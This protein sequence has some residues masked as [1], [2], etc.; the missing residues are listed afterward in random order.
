MD[1][2]A[3]V[4]NPVAHSK[5]PQI[6]E[7]FARETGQD[8]SYERILAPLGGFAAAA[9]C[10]AAEGGKGINVTVPFKLD[11]YAMASTHSVRAQEAKA[12]NTLVWRDEAWHA[13]NTD[14]VGL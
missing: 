1:R 12:C 13:E 11:A 4:G 2:Y 6:H 8:M 9:Q 5:S 3:V 10:F 7:V 14:G